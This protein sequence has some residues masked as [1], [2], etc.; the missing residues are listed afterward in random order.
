MKAFFNGLLAA[1][2]GVIVNKQSQ[3]PPVGQDR[4]ADGAKQT[5]SEPPAEPV[6]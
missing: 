4:G 5:Q 1:Q 2:T 6:V 3:F